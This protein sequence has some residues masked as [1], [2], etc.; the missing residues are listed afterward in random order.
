MADEP[1]RLLASMKSVIALHQNLGPVITVRD[2]RKLQEIAERERRWVVE[3]LDAF[4]DSRSEASG[5]AI[6][7]L[8]IVEQLDAMVS[9]APGIGFAGGASEAGSPTSRVAAAIGGVETLARSVEDRLR[10][11]T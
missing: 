10:G 1:A 3:V 6:M 11:P 4:G 5:Y 7:L 9:M 2:M 8:E